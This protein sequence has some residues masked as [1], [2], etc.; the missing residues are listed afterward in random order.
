MKKSMII[1][2]LCCIAMSVNAASYFTAGDTVRINPNK[3]D[4]YQP[5]EFYCQLDGYIDCYNLQ[6]T[7]PVGVT[8]KLV[9]GIVPL[10][11]QTIAYY[12]RYGRIQHEECPLQVSA[13]YG[14][15][16]SHTT[17]DG[18]WLQPQEEG[19]EMSVCYEYYG[20]IKWEPGYHRM[21]YLNMYIDPKF[22]R[23]YIRIDGHLASGFDRRGPVLSDY[24][25]VKK[26]YLWVGYERGDVS[27]NGIFDIGDVTLLIDYTLGRDIQLDEFQLAA[28]D[29]NGDGRVDIDDVTAI[30]D[31]NLGK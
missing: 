8:P 11:G 3:L 19:E 25:F 4:G 24:N 18:Y 23:G 29:V 17:A 20:S 31:K 12:D 14:T 15:I 13:A 30:I 10:E 16:A 5:I 27:G 28:A 1:A 26:T 21:F 6:M 22:R 2:A 7:Y 9:A